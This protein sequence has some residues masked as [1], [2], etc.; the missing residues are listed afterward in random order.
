M[1]F[2]RLQTLHTIATAKR[3]QVKILNPAM[4][5]KNWYEKITHTQKSSLIILNGNRD[6]GDFSDFCFF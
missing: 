5:E 2:S 6:I 1:P 3:I 4:D